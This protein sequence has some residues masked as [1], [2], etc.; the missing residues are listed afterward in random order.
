M[1]KKYIY[2]YYNIKKK[3]A[4]SYKLAVGGYSFLRIV[5]ESDLYGEVYPLP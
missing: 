2:L 1:N 4:V 5:L 3:T